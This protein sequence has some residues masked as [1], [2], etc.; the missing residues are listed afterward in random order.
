[1]SFLK[2]IGG[3][4]R[5][6]GKWAGGT[7]GFAKFASGVQKA[8]NFVTKWTPKIISGVKTGLELFRGGVGFL[9]KVGLLSKMDKKG[10]FREFGNKTGLYKSSDA[11]T[12]KPEATG[13]NSEG[14]TQTL[15]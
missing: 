4:G 15:G 2:A 14:T 5:F 8:A 12:A 9:D 13:T 3:I 6:F 1:M 11:A 10:K 7:G